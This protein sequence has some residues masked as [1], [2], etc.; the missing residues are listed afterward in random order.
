M[1]VSNNNK[2]EIKDEDMRKNSTL[3][4]L[5]ELDIPGKGDVEKAIEHG[6]ANMLHKIN[7]KNKKNYA[8]NK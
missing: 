2:L 7:L 5:N 4:R 3:Y 1:N 6:K 8:G